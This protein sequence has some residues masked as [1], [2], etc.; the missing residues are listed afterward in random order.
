MTS[1]LQWENSVALGVTAPRLK[2]PA[3]ILVFMKARVFRG[4]LA[5][6]NYLTDGLSKRICKDLRVKLEAN[7]FEIIYAMIA[8]I[9]PQS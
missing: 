2:K 8:S 4:L 3:A 5:Q 1:S 6:I 7:M 9:E